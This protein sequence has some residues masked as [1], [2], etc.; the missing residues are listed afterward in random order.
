[1]E[2]AARSSAEAG[3]NRLK[4]KTA[5]GASIPSE[6]TAFQLSR[7]ELYRAVRPEA[8]LA[9]S[10]VTCWLWQADRRRARRGRLCF[11]ACRRAAR[12]RTGAKV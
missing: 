8:G 4:P 11:A 10:T 3:G 6:P 5:A 12:L 7:K 9:M 2:G 1:M